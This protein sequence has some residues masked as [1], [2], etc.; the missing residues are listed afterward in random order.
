[1]GESC[2]GVSSKDAG[3]AKECKGCPNASYCSQPAQPDPD[4]KI[5]QENLRGVKT[6]VAIMSGKGGVGKSTVVRNIAESVSSRGITTCILDLDLSGPSIPRLTGTDG[7]S[8][9]ETSGIIQPIEVNKFL[10]VVSVGYLQDCGEG[11]MFSSSFKTGII[12][13]FLA[14]CNYEGVDVL[15]LDTP[16]NVTD[17]HLGMVNFIKPKFAIVVTTP[18]KFSLQDVI[19]QIDF[20]RKAKISVLGVIENMKR[21][22]CP[23]CSHQKNVFVNTEVESYSKSN[24]IPYL[25]SIDLRQDIA[26]A[27]DIGR[28]TRE[29]I[30]DRMAD[31]VLSIHES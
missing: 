13:K 27:S 3:K 29:E 9:C 1:M 10:K 15:L 17:E 6:I 23:R 16:P 26:K 14:Q 4:I 19:R 12:K 7:M 20:C 28:P 21:F 8:M 11:I 31:A 5:I 30:F 22:V 2:P 18:Q 25:G 24:G